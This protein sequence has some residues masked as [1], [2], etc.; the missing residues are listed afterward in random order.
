MSEARTW[1]E[2][3]GLDLYADAFVA[4]ALDIDLLLRT[5]VTR[6]PTRTIL[7]GAVRADLDVIHVVSALKTSSPEPLLRAPQARCCSIRLGNSARAT[8]RLQPM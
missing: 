5:L 1:L 2:S 7:K 3:V 8:R 6:K 4:N